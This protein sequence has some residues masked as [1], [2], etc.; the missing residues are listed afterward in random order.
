MERRGLA[1]YDGLQ[2]RR[3]AAVS[4]A[5]FLRD[6]EAFV[7]TERALSP[8]SPTLLHGGPAAGLLARA[9]E[10]WSQGSG[11]LPA[12]FTFDLFRPVPRAP[13]RTEAVPVRE[14]RR[15][16]VVEARL[17]ADGVVVG[18]ASA[19]LIRPS[20][21]EVPPT[22]R[23]GGLP[24][25]GPERLPSSPVGARIRMP[26]REGFHTTLE[27]RR[28]LLGEPGGGGRAA[29]WVRLPCAF[30]AGEPVSPLVHLAAV[31]D[32]ANGLAHIS[33][34]PEVGFINADITLVV[35]RAPEPGWVGFDV[36]SGAE[37]HGIGAITGHLY[38]ERGRVGSLMQT[39]LAN[40]RRPS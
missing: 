25:P 30:V 9:V 21:V 34:A 19:L 27:V 39:L 8:W 29:A 32:F 17:V 12:R 10:E 20:K 28:V 37:P 38:D 5:V 6:G 23:F 7:P 18:R 40:P 2:Y 11:F 1:D 14:G 26:G 33:A 15:I 3:G 31:S 36:I 22:A 4:D 16:A 35:H 24:F 13:L